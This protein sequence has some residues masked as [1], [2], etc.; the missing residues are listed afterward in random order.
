LLLEHVCV[1]RL[2]IRDS[3][4]EV[5]TFIYAIT[6][7]YVDL[8]SKW[9]VG[10]IAVHDSTAIMAL[11]RPE[12]FLGAKCRV[13]VETSGDITR[14]VTIADWANHWKKTPQTLVLKKVNSAAFKDLY[15]DYVSM[16]AGTVLCC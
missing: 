4:G 5:G 3:C 13:D 6:Q 11:I 8:L 15:I 10:R 12:I 1:P 7:H 2:R 14:G 9:K 16:F